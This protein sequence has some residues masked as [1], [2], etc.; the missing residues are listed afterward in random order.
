MKEKER[1]DNLVFAKK[2]APSREQA[3]ALIMSGNSIREWTERR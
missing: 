1:L 2:F 3:K